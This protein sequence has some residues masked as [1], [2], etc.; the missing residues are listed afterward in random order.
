MHE[1]NLLQL[2]LNLLLVL[3]AL[4][5]ERNVTNAGERIGL[6]QSATSHALGR[7]REVFNDPLFVRS[8]K[9][10]M[11]TPRALELL[12]PLEKILLDIEQLIQPSVFESKTAQ[13]TI[14]LAA[15]DYSIVVVLPKV[16]KLICDNAPH[17]N[18]ECHHWSS[19]I[20][21]NLRNGA[22]DL[23]LGVLNLP[24]PSELRFQ[25][26]F[27][28][29]LVSVVRSDHPIAQTDLTIES[30]VAW[31]HASITIPNS[32]T[33][34]IM[35]SPLK[36][37]DN[38]LSSLGVKR[39]V[40]LK[41]PHFLAA[42]MIVSQSD[43]ILTL[44]RR[45]AMLYAQYTNLTLLEPPIELGQ[46]DYMQFWHERLDYDQRHIWLRELIASQTHEI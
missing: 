22:I 26:L 24:Q 31:P 19:D 27:V 32:P 40:M 39:R 1:I 37:V 5:K 25:K 41:L 43:L 3:R 2:D 29:D 38:A 13:G 36:H 44:P 10:M 14:H 30:F 17:L 45:I 8:T 46:Y 21:D 7:L 18:L 35:H 34:P 12:E 16:L 4:L 42:P 33:S 15:S 28:E 6:S 23:G 9:G 11:P 20:L